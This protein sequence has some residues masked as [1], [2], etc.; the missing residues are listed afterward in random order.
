[1]DSH[2]H[3]PYAGPRRTTTTRPSL[4]PVPAAVAQARAAALFLHLATQAQVQ[5]R[6]TGGG[7]ESIVAVVAVTG[8]VVAVAA[9]RPTPHAAGPD[10]D[11]APGRGLHL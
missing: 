6:E 7:R 2:L 9:L 3:V 8:R 11:V 1:M 4:R 10:L 5:I